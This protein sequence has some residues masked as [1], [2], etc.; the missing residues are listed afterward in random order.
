[1]RFDDFVTDRPGHAK[2]LVPSLKRDHEEISTIPTG[3]V[4][5]AGRDYLA[6]MS[7][8]H[9]EPQGGRWTTN[10]SGLAYSDDDGQTWVE[11]P[12]ARRPNTPAFDDRFQMIAFAQRAHPSK[13]GFV[14]AIGT[15]GGRFGAA[16]LARVSPKQLLD[17]AAYEYWTGLG[18]WQ[19]GS[20]A[21]ATPIVPG[22]VGELSV[23]YNEALS[24]WMM[25]TL[26]EDRAAIVLRLAS[27]LTGP[28]SPPIALATAGTYPGLYGGFLHPAS[29]GSEI[30][31]TMTQYSEYNVTLMRAQ[32]PRDAP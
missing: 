27:E 16:H 17:Q 19:R 23:S 29:N 5:I 24:R 1:V 8:R 7:V 32:L 31:F 21:I 25:L 11:V 20:S 13:D 28:W 30:Y 15:P 14:Y 4:H 26:D 6:Y 3:G 9:F 2:E 10:H 18:G 12:S 22:P